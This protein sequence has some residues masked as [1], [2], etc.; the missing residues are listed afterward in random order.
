MRIAPLLWQ[1]LEGTTMKKLIF[2]LALV[3]TASMPA[4]S[5]P[6]GG[7]SF[8]LFYNSLGSYGNWISVE[9]GV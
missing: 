5:D 7:V 4:L 8:D 3:L 9:G 2:V 1:S 6:D